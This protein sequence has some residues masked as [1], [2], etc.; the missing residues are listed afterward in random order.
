MP[1][2]ITPKDSADRMMGFT[3]S[4]QALIEADPNSRDLA[5]SPAAM[6]EQIVAW[7][8]EEEAFRQREATVNAQR[9]VANAYLD[10]ACMDFGGALLLACG[11][12]TSS[13][14]FQTFFKVAPNK[15]IKKPLE[16]Q[17]AEMKV[18][19]TLSDPV[20]EQH[21]STL[22]EWLEAASA[23]AEATRML[24]AERSALKVKKEALCAALTTQR[25]TLEE[26]LR[27]RARERG[28]PRSWP[29][30]FF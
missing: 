12:D 22:S 29:A 5:P 14:R 2:K 25:D 20:L 6:M 7:R 24:S 21:R 30:S 9:I 8:S 11:R 26:A 13:T 1:R 27:A 28:L 17:I 4:V 18:W 3:S 19:L 23:A 16:D 15:F 10:R